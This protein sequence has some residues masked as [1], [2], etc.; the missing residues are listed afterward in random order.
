MSPSCKEI[1]VYVLAEH[2]ILRVSVGVCWKG[3]Y[4]HRHVVQDEQ[5]DK[6]TH[7]DYWLSGTRTSGF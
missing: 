3:V 7:V 6:F 5:N 1:L 4:S 2:L